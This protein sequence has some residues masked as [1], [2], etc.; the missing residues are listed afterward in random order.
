[1]RLA[2]LLALIILNAV[3]LPDVHAQL[4]GRDRNRDGG[5]RTRFGGRPGGDRDGQPGGFG[6]RLDQNGDGRIDQNELNKIPEGFRQAMQ[7]RG[8]N[9]KPGLS[10]EEFSNS[11]RQQFERSRGEG[12]R[13]VEERR[14][15]SRPDER[16]AGNR[17]Q[18]RPPAPF[19][20]RQKER[21]TVDLPPKYSELDTDYD[22]QVGLY[23]WITARRESL[24]QFDD[25]DIDLDGVLTPRELMLYDDVSASGSPAPTSFKRNRMTIIGGPLATPTPRRTN[26][27]RGKSNLSEKAREKHADFASSKAFPY[28]D[29]NKDGR[30]TMEELH[31]DEK[32]K[33]VIQTLEKAEI[34]VEAMSQQEFADRWVEAQEVFARQKEEARDEQKR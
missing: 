8:I 10:V 1:M 27:G 25:I 14:P 34:R 11:M 5:D 21:L 26:G 4:I 12:G 23:E 3:C 6:S 13:S 18:Y 24:H 30:I 7:S 2:S 28:I 16:S 33:R 17:S 31:R 22:G 20:P 9:L 15:E 32:T 19:R 29:V